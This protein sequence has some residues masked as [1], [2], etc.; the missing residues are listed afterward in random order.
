MEANGMPIEEVQAAL[1]A[2]V[3]DEQGAP[4]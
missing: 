3:Q 2:K 4:Q 1:Q